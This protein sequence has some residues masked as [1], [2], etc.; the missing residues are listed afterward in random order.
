MSELARRIHAILQDRVADRLA[1]S[2][3][4]AELGTNRFRA[5]RAFKRCYGLAPREFL[6]AHR[7]LLAKRALAAGLG[8]AE[9]ACQYGFTDQ[10]HLSRQFKRAF[11]I[12]PGRFARRAHEER[13]EDPQ[14]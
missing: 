3:L 8:P 12:T 1:I 13:T 6:L 7:L 4:A 10:S 9:V 2:A 14:G 11:G 5:Y